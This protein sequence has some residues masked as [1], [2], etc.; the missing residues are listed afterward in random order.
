MA[1]LHCSL[2]V[3][4]FNVRQGCLTFALALLQASVQGAVLLWCKAVTLLQVVRIVVTVV[5]GLM[6]G[7]AIFGASAG[8]LVCVGARLLA[9]RRV[10]LRARTQAFELVYGFRDERMREGHFRGHALVNLPLN[11]FLQK[12]NTEAAVTYIDGE[13]G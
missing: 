10:W 8:A 7:G 2:V 13:G 12:G 11:A 3:A 4:V 1:L 9:A 6:L 5:V